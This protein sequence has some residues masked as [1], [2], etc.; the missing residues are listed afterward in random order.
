MFNFLKNIWVGIVCI[1]K[2]DV[3]A[4]E[5]LFFNDALNHVYLFKYRLVN[6][7]EN[8]LTN[9]GYRAGL[10]GKDSK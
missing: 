5:S 1:I 10:I 8:H 9:G 4:I 7:S 2:L 3:T 6:H